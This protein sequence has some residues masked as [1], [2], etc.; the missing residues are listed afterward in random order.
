MESLKPM[1]GMTDRN[2]SSAHLTML[3]G[4]QAAWGC[5]NC[6]WTQALNWSTI[7]LELCLGVL[8]KPLLWKVKY[9]SPARK[10]K[11]SYTFSWSIKGHFPVLEVGNQ[12]WPASFQPPLPPCSLQKITQHCPPAEVW[13][14]G[15]PAYWLLPPQVNHEYEDKETCSDL[16]CGPHS[17][18]KLC[19]C[20]KLHCWKQTTQ[21]QNPSR[22]SGVLEHKSC[23]CTPGDVSTG[24]ASSIVANHGSQEMWWLGACSHSHEHSE[25]QDGNG[26]EGVVE[27]WMASGVQTMVSQLVQVISKHLRVR[28]CAFPH[29]YI[30]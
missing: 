9:Q 29:F 14:Q 2:S 4:P 21:V 11:C 22:F 13:S 23:L 24:Q 30:F 10:K 27:G 20:I 8:W 26:T 16:S 6:A 28:Q 15:S 1:C 5:L 18:Q 17:A 19:F 7:V 25:T 12:L 3:L